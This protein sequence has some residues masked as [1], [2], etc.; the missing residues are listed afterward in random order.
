MAEKQDIVSEEAENAQGF[1]KIQALDGI[2][3]PE[4]LAALSD[5]DREKLGKKATLKMDIVIMPVLVI[6]YILNYLDRQNIASAKL[7]NIEQDLN[8]SPVQYQTAVSILFCSYILFQVPSNMIASRI[9]WPGVY[10]CLSM[11]LWGAISAVMASIHN[12]A[13]LIVARIFL[14]A[15]EAVFFPGAIYFLSLFYSRKQFALRMAILYSGSQLGNAFGG[16]FAIGI[17]KLDGVHGISGWRWLFLV[18]GVMTVGLAIVFALILPNSKNKILGVSKLEI[19]WIQWN[20]NQDSGQSEETHEMTAM[21]GLQAA[22]R[23]PKTWLF[24]GILYCTYIVGAVSNFFPSVV[25]GLGYDRNK[26]YLLTAPPFLLCVITMLINGFHSDR[27]SE[28]FYHVTIALCVTLVANIIA[29]S[30]LNIA[31]RYVAMMLLPGSFYASTIVTLS[32]ITGSL[33]QPTAKRASAIAFINA[34]CNTPNIWCSYLYSGG[35]RYVTA[36]AVN[37]A[38]TG[39]AIAF[40][41]AARIHLKRLNNKLERGED[42][43]RHGPTAAQVASGYRY[44]L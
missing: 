20:F 11:A 9:K 41:I 16:L 10:I 2:I 28:R 3:M 19:L 5:E 18:E 42:A 23:D 30:T 40:A 4:E 38:A 25:G 6:M 1:D 15:V 21:Q 12:F 26:T 32:W 34:I 39:L 22:V 7:A 33:S 14:G 17:L 44:M 29:V 24:I 37:A 13:G 43:G 8:M 35:P 36:F 27:A 31:A